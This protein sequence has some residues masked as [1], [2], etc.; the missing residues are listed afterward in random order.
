MG[1]AR[2]VLLTYTVRLVLIPLGAVTGVIIARWL[3]PQ[4]QGV[5]ATIG[6]YVA[7][8]AMLG[9]LGLSAAATSAVAGNP[10]LAPALLA[11][12]R[13]SGGFAGL[14]AVG[15][16]WALRT[17]LPDAFEGIPVELLLLGALALPFTLIS[18]QFH[19]VL[20]GLQRVRQY[21]LV[22]ALERL[23]MFSSALVLLLVLGFGVT[24]LVAATTLVAVIKLGVFQ[25]QLTPQSKRWRPDPAVFG[26]LRGF[27]GRA[28]VAA[29]LAFLVLR[30]DIMLIHGLLGSDP[31]GVYS[32]AVQIATVLM[33]LPTAMGNLLFPRIAAAGTE[34][35]SAFTAALCRH[36]VLLISLSSL[37]L[38]A[39]GWW[40]V[41]LVYGEPY[42]AA[43]LALGILLPGVWC[44]SVQILL[45]N[46]LAG[47]DYPLFLPV[48]WLVLL[49]IN[50]GLN[51]LLIPWLGIAG[52][53]A[54]SS[55]AYA[56]ALILVL[57]YWL[58]RFPAIPLRRLLLL[59]REELRTFAGR[60]FRA[61][62]PRMPDDGSVVP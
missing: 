12:A 41:R 50:V 57:R 39:A 23:L 53:A 31:T 52:A 46:D 22:D 10:G 32:V 14:V 19:G 61:L 18:S 16:L 15:L 9:N 4:G 45:A 20:L 1:F 24:E 55:L 27:S 36:S 26:R 33:V 48:V 3:G 38:A 62:R 56:L 13:F 51:L 60:L 40:V 6:A 43:A 8:A 29:L 54:S 58:R 5:Y 59:D 49:T 25:L 21:T 42:Q 11:N 17:A 37:A 47:R 34:A 35:S 28:Y 30:S 44:M 2:Q 7:T